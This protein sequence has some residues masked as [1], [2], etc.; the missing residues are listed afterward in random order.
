MID[1]LRKRM[2]LISSFA[3]FVVFSIIFSAITI[4]STHLLNSRI[5]IITDLISDGNGVFLP[6]NQ[7]NPLPTSPNI[8][9]F[10]TSE[11][12]F[13]TRF[14]TVWFDIDGNYIRSDL[15]AI[16]SVTEN[17][18]ED[19]AETIITKSKTRGW[20]DQFRYKIF[21][22]D[23]EKGIVFVDGSMDRSMAKGLVITAAI[24]LLGGIALIFL[25]IVIVSKKAVRPIAQSYEKQ[26]QFITDANH[27]LKTPLTLIMANIDIIE[28][29]QGHSEWLD[30][31]RIEGQHMS[32]LIG[33]LTLLNR[34]DESE[35]SVLKVTFSYSDA[36]NDV[37]SEFYSLIAQKGLCLTAT[38]QPDVM[39][40]GDEAAVRRLI[41]I[42]LDNA[43]K[44]CDA[45]GSII[46][47]MEKKHYTKLIVENTYTG[48]ETLELDKLFD[49][50]YRA[51]KAR[52]EG[53][54]FGI[55]LSLA[56]SIAESHN[57][58]I[59]AYQA[60]TGRIGFRTTLRDTK[61]K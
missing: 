36:C 59:Q 53:T 52:T 33:Q 2:I 28:H 15:N 13:S 57:G 38:I 48:V 20:V 14:F 19:Y 1:K 3:V 61:I 51:D 42:L 8:P 49:R 34:L 58:R 24:V 6:F 45:K 25:L 35:S 60:G 9:D 23:N 27:E 46:V 17:T 4:F 54:G 50:F 32:E 21:E 7:K 16:S 44:Y 18:A 5:D 11:T 55:G 31:I 10:F 41:T 39:L 22:T 37:I 12:P 56:K 30:D 40:F 47:S 29:E 26:K 43:V